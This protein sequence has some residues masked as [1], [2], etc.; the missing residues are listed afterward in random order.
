MTKRKPPSPNAPMTGDPEEWLNYQKE[1]LGREEPL[2]YP[3]TIEMVLDD[4]SGDM[5]FEMLRMRAPKV[6]EI[7]ASMLDN[8]PDRNKG[9]Y[10]GIIEHYVEAFEKIDQPPK[11]DESP[12]RPPSALDFDSVK[13][14]VIYVI[15][16][17]NDNWSFSGHRQFNAPNDDVND[18]KIRQIGTFSGNRGIMLRRAAT[19][20]RKLKYDY[21]VTVHNDVGRATDIIIDPDDDPTSGSG[22][23][24]QTGN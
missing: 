21:Y 3:V 20:P 23:G 22:G 5:K 8:V 1:F 19:L 11:A 12:L 13:R 14:S 4:E 6:L 18:P 7:S 16:L 10:E 9:F 15:Y 2:L 24:N 17:N